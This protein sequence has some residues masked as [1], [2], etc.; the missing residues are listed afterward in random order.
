MDSKKKISILLLLDLFQMIFS[1]WLLHR[2]LKYP[3]AWLMW[4]SAPGFLL[5]LWMCFLQPPLLF[6][7]L[8]RSLTLEFQFLHSLLMLFVLS[9]L[10]HVPALISIYLLITLKFASGSPFVLQT[11]LNQCFFRIEFLR[12]IHQSNISEIEFIF[13]LILL[14]SVL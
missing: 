1:H 8:Y 2:A 5:Y 13:S 10:I 11:L 14:F 12:S 9:D 3:L 7:L 6:S 4:W